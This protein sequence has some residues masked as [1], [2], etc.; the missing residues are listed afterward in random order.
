[1]KKLFFS[2]LC[3]LAAQGASALDVVATTASMGVLA[4]EVGGP[5]V[6]VV[7]L[8]APDRDAHTVQARPSMMRALRDADLLVA[9]GAELEIGWLPPAVNGAANARIQPGRP[10]WFEAAAQ[11]SLLDAGQV[12]DRAQGDVHPD[13]NPHFQ[14]DPMRMAQAAKALGERMA[15]LDPANAGGYRQRALAFAAAIEQRVGNWRQRAAAAPGALL[16]HRDG[17]Y[18][19]AFVGRP[20][21]GFIEPIAGVPPTASH[22]ARLLDRLKGSHG[23]IIRTP[24]QP[25]AGSERLSAELGWPV[26]VLPLEP[27][28]GGGAAA[29]FALVDRWV[30]ALSVK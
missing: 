27:E 18:L 28:A 1:M 23:V 20:V 12:A 5:Q 15:A 7:E 26:R 14:L 30:D 24:Y 11:L 19:L 8:V 25:A 10:G 2:L 4:R 6:H 22:L 29:Y 3:L 13:G 16:H 17:S 9:V 21:L